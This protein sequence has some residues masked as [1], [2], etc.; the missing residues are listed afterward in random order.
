MDYLDG[1]DQEA[2]VLARTSLGSYIDV[3]D[4]NCKCE[5]TCTCVENELLV[6]P[7][8]GEQKRHGVAH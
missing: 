1:I 4:A 5:G 8:R 3:I 6:L 2:S 7:L